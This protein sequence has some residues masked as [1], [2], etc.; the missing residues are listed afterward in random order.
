MTTAC[1]VPFFPEIGPWG[2][3]DCNG[4]WE[5]FNLIFPDYLKLKTGFPSFH[6]EDIGAG[7]LH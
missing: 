2:S 5:H 3:N 7:I 6:P 1:R 4:N